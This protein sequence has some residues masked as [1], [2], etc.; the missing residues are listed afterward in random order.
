M[1]LKL[2]YIGPRLI[3]MRAGGGVPCSAKADDSGKYMVK[4]RSIY[5]EYGIICVK[6][7][8]NNCLP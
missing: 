3:L 7:N 2:D 8:S 5:S 1:E 4:F 6:I